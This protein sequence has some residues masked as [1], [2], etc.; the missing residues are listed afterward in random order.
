MPSALCTMKCQAAL[1]LCGSKTALSRSRKALQVQAPQIA[2]LSWPRC[3]HPELHISP[4]PAVAS[5]QAQQ[6]QPL[7]MLSTEA[8]IIAS[9]AAR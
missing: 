9:T 7:L 3:P 2:R 5:Q 4:L 6:R 8:V 1:Y